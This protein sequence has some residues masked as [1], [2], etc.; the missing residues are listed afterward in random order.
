M[1]AT[2][3]PKV[4]SYLDRLAAIDWW[5]RVYDVD[6]IRSAYAARL[7]ATGLTREIVIADDPESGDARAARAAL[8]ALDAW[9]ARA[10]WD[11]WDARGAIG[12]LSIALAHEPDWLTALCAVYAPMIDAYLAGSGAHILTP[13]S[14]VVILAPRVKLD[15]QRRLRVPLRARVR[16]V[17]R[18]GAE[19]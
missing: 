19:G 3:T 7:T 10:A 9:D 15:T 6:A 11:A 13:D 17:R 2:F 1:S 8:D 12:W 16:P 14:V 18:A 4:Q 5:N